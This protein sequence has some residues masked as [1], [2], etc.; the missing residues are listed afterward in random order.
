MA[1]VAIT[2]REARIPYANEAKAEKLERES[3]SITAGNAMIV[4]MDQKVACELCAMRW[5]GAFFLLIGI[6]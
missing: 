5:E 6:R 2:P 1:L 3:P 4:A